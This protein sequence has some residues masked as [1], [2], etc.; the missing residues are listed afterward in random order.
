MDKRSMSVLKSLYTNNIGEDVAVTDYQETVI[1]KNLQQSR[2][3]G[4]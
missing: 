4:E 2:G 3:R 1:D